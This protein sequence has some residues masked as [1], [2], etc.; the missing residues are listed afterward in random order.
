M[1]ATDAPTEDEIRAREW[2]TR[3][4]TIG[5]S[6]E[7]LYQRTIATTDDPEPFHLAKL[8]CYW[9]EYRA[10]AEASPEGADAIDPEMP[11]KEARH[12]CVDEFG[13]TPWEGS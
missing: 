11:S 7:A 3:F 5:D 1:T 9:V 12:Y 13:L 2:Q 6:L 4:E 10:L 8:R